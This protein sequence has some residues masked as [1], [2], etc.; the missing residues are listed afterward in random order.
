[1]SKT[2]SKKTI[3]REKLKEWRML[4]LVRDDYKCQICETKPTKPH[5][6]HIIPKQVKETRYD[7]NNGITLCF[8]HHK[9]GF[10]SPHM[11]ALWFFIWFRET[12]PE[13]FNYLIDK[14]K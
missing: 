8:N 14:L 13:Q 2:K 12:K 7:I 1:M 3:E 5:V 11:N 4:V 10:H 9:V 6:H